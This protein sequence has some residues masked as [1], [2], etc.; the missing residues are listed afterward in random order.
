MM[1]RDPSTAPK[2]GSR[3]S[4]I[5]IPKPK[6]AKAGDR[7]EDPLYVMQNNI[8]YDGMHYIK[9]QLIPPFCRL[10]HAVFADT[11]AE[12]QDVDKYYENHKERT[13]VYRELFV[14]PHMQQRIQ[15]LPKKATKGTLTGFVTRTPTCVRCRK[16][17]VRSEKDRQV[18]SALCG[19][20]VC[21]DQSHD[22]F[23]RY[24][25]QMADAATRRLQTRQTCI[26]C[27]DGT[28]YEEILCEN[29]TCD[30]WFTRFKAQIDYDKTT[31]DA[32]RYQDLL[33][34]QDL[35]W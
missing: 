29:R 5:I 6:H 15:R 2:V 23:V 10:L 27:Q 11:E 3:V 20:R 14:G 8:P 7:C 34:D 26:E 16:V 35:N 12:R 18:Y 13:S 32:P 28:P 17:A 31:N 22:T 1:K 21:R 30:N 4:S 19:D 9:T 33:N 24:A 25:I